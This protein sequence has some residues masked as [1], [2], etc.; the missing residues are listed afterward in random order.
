M[1]LLPP[2]WAGAGWGCCL[3]LGQTWLQSGKDVRAGEGWVRAL[4][5]HGAPHPECLM[6]TKET[7][8]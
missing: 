1:G 4:E 7:L 6:E 8:L 3:Q 5:V 2:V